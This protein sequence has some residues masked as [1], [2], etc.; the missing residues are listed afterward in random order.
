MPNWLVRGDRVRVLELAADFLRRSAR[1]EPTEELFQQAC[2]LLQ[3]FWEAEG[4][5]LWRLDSDRNRLERLAGSDPEWQL[6]AELALEAFPDLARALDEPEPS[7]VEQVAT[8]WRPLPPPLV[9]VP[10]LLL[11]PVGVGRR[12]YGCL[13]ARF[14]AAASKPAPEE[15]E[16]GVV[17]S[18]GLGLLLES[19]ARGQECR[20]RDRRQQAQ[21][22][23]E[24]E[25]LRGFGG[26]LQRLLA[27][28]CDLSQA[29]AVAL[30]ESEEDGFRQV[31]AAGTPHLLPVELRR[32][33]AA[34]FPWQRALAEGRPLTLEPAELAGTLEPWLPQLVRSGLRLRVIPLLRKEAPVGVLLLGS[35]PGAAGSEE[36]EILWPVLLAA[37]ALE[38]RRW[39]Q[40]ERRQRHCFR[41]LFEQ[42]GEGIFFLDAAGVVRLANP[43][44]L[45][46]T[47]Y[48]LDELQGHSLAE[49]LAPT[50]W[51]S[52]CAW[53]GSDAQQIFTAELS[54]RTQAGSWE[55]FRM[56]LDPPPLLE[57]PSLRA[58][59]PGAILGR[60]RPTHRHPRVEPELRSHEVCLQAVLD[61][62][63]DGVWLIGPD[64]RIEFANHR[65][66]QLFGANAQQLGPGEPQLE[67]LRALKDRF[68]DSE[69]ALRGWRELHHNPD[70]VRWDELELLW[71]RR[72][73][74]ERFCRPLLDSQHRLLGRLEV[75]RDISAGR[76]L[77]SKV[78]Q[79][80]RLA[81][82]GQLLSGVA[83]ELNNPLTAL[84]GYTQLLR[85]A[86]LPAHLREKTELLAREA[87]RAARIVQNL[88]LFVREG[89]A[90]KES[91]SVLDALER[92]LSLRAYELRVA[93]IRVARDY[94]PGLPPVWGNPHQLQQVF[95]NLLLNAEQAIRSRREEGCLTLRLRG[96]QAQAAPEEKLVE[97]EIADDGPGISPSLLP[98]IFDPFFTTKP[99][100]E[101]T[102][103][104][105]AISQAIVKEHGGEILAH[106][107]PGQGATFLVRLPARPSEAVAPLPSKAAPKR[108]KDVEETARILVVDD[109]PAVA[110][111][112]ADVLRQQGYSIR[113]HTEGRRALAE[114]FEQP[115]HLAICDIRMPEVDGPAF[116]RA[117]RDHR[118]GLARRLLFTTGDT[119]AAETAEFLAEARLPY[120]AKPFR[121]EE[122]RT[123]VRNFLEELERS[124][125]AGNGDSQT[126]APFDA[127][128]ERQPR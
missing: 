116:Y 68:Q 73:V 110:N 41:R 29:Q 2:A 25:L 28:A 44:L 53:L 58:A 128:G 121:I 67:V 112:I 61:S 115:F 57:P 123:R 97:I 23:L 103:L 19:A 77:E 63:H 43:A 36:E 16:A 80:E 20:R 81:A 114:A 48:A 52:V 13:M 102:G 12:R 76:L 51:D 105:L 107:T 26:D 11:V 54:W 39:Q 126:G 32:D 84:A 62:V 49:F 100:Q 5:A 30:Y 59:D 94:D 93:N 90:E 34:L 122:L 46:A 82:V 31:A 55:G 35:P 71:P 7:W 98:Y 33:E 74:L 95:L 42:A 106:S 120:L 101:G 83:H 6:F 18:G 15:L 17:L 78:L 113:V 14:P 124:G 65:L 104:G 38:S 47:G 125:A 60:L 88:L 111:L 117:L 66:G 108:K 86:P 87:E 24:K 3:R 9:E 91:I 96:P 1:G 69:T 119:L 79:R 127:K 56:V 21:R 40:G 64:G 70:Q 118:C 89:K 72:R 99:S 8:A 92:A 85:A 75:Y 37:Q 109:E 50:D 27:A 10:N 4:V 45:H 22:R